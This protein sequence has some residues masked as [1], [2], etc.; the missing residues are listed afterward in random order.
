MRRKKP[1]QLLFRDNKGRTCTIPAD[2]KLKDAHKLGIKQIKLEPI[3][4]P[5]PDGWFAHPA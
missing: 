3:G 4:T 2:M 5:L 1:E